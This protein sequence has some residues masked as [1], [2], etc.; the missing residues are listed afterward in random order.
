MRAEGRQFALAERHLR[1]DHKAGVAFSTLLVAVIAVLTL[2]VTIPIG[3]ATPGMSGVYLTG[4]DYKDGRLSFEGDCKSK[5]HRL[6]LHDVRNKPYIDV[7]H[8]SEK[9]RY[10][11]SDL[12]GFRACDG[13]DYRFSSKLEY[14]ILEARDLYIYGRETSIPHGRVSSVVMNYYFSVGPD[15][16]I[17]LLTREHLK[18]AFPENHRF[19]DLLDANFGSGE[20]I[21][22]YDQF[23]KM[24]KVNRLLIASRE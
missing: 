21:E 15:G 12:F 17:L 3:A 2:G 23:H 20:A 9:H 11:K 19:H 16:P 13:H 7:T 22:E 1:K 5:A 8:E 24:F 10:L 4:A 18:Q 6:E 14:Q